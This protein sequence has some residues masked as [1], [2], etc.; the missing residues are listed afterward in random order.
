MNADLELVSIKT[1]TDPLDGL[2]Y[3]PRGA[4]P[5]AAAMIFHGNCHNFYTGPSRFLPEALVA[6]GIACLAFNRRGHDMVSSLDG[7]N[8]GG[9]SFQL[10][11]EAIAD[12]RYAAGFLAGRGFP[13]PIVIG[14]SNGGVLAAQ[15]GADHPE[16]PAL[17]LMSAHRGGAGITAAISAKGLFGRDR[18]AELLAQAEHMIAQGRGRELMLLPGWWW[19]ISAESLLDYSRN[20]PATLDNA[21]R[22]KCPVLY[23][24]G[25]QEPED[26]YPAR[27]FAARCASP[28]EAVILPNCDHFYTGCEDATAALVVGWLRQTVATA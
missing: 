13:H 15:H 23:V 8:V 7:R 6:Q 16:T 5:R 17:V 25:D 1:D 3:T 22:M 20:M 11:H 19:V 10:A 18:L 4:T 24:C 2:Y 26:L 21:R 9:G 28:C 14:H 27:E 12:G